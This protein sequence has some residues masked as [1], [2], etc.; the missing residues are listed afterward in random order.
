MF[1]PVSLIG[2]ALSSSTWT[3]F[4]RPSSAISSDANQVCVAVSKVLEDR[5]D[6]ES[7][8]GSKST[9]L[10]QLMTVI[11]DL[12]VDEDQEPVASETLHN[13]ELFV[14]ALPDGL[15]SPMIGVDPDGAISMTW[16]ASRTRQFSV[17]VSNSDRLAYAWI[18]GS[19]K[20][21]A[22]ERFRSSSLT[23]RFLTS[24]KSIVANDA[25]AIRAA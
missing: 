24:L 5:L 18:D 1:E 8:F 21:H 22:V 9:V 20:G 2:F 19:D 11:G 12:T 17:S 7:L 10:W 3:D 6:S 4:V 13:V 16:A 25:A 15:P 14:L 23:E